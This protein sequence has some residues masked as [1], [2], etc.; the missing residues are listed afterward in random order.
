[1]EVLCKSQAGQSPVLLPPWTSYQYPQYFWRI[2][3]H[4]A[5]TVPGICVYN[6]VDGR[7]EY[8]DLPC[9]LSHFEFLYV[10]GNMLCVCCYLIKTRRPFV[11]YF[12][13]V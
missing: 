5:E 6:N 1:M 4:R 8:L 12:F 9:N 11:I 7:G 3:F 13:Y 10:I 2:H